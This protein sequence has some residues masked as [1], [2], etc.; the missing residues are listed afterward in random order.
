MRHRFLCS[1]VRRACGCTAS[2]H[3]SVVVHTTINVPL[4]RFCWSAAISIMLDWALQLSFFLACYVLTERRIDA[5]RIDCC[6]CFKAATSEGGPAGAVTVLAQRPAGLMS[7]NGDSWLQQL[8]NR[9]VL[10][11]M[12]NPVSKVIMICI[13]AGLAVVGAVGVGRLKEGLPLGDLAPDDH[14]IRAFD[15][16][17]EQ[18]EDN[19]GEPSV[20]SPLRYCTLLV[21]ESA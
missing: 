2:C 9:T 16:R 1:V 14:Y 6:C 7:A 19:S 5:S 12:L 15:D 4:R 10:P 21:H 13:V 3:A 20:M 11:V 8:L 18:F 17:A